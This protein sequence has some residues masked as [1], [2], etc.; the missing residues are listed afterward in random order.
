MGWSNSSYSM[1]NVRVALDEDKLVKLMKSWKAKFR[2]SNKRDETEY[3]SNGILR[4]D[5]RN[6]W[7]KGFLSNISTKYRLP[8]LD[9]LA[10]RYIPILDEDI[11][12]FFELC[13]DE[14]DNLF[15]NNYVTEII[16]LEKLEIDPY[17]DSILIATK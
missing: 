15:I 10:L 14:V 5:L 11:Q 4:L 6:V 3:T 16:R 8:G 17:Y 12:H 1:D 9:T 2:N 7:C 13:M